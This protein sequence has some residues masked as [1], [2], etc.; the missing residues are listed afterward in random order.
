MMIEQLLIS[1]LHSA[2][3]E[4][5]G[6]DIQ[7]NLAQVQKTRPEFEGDYTI[8]VFPLLRTSRKGPE[9]TAEEIGNY[10][11]SNLNEVTAFNIIKGFLNLSISHHYWKEFFFNN[12][13][14]KRFG[15]Y[16]ETNNDPVVVEYS[17]PNN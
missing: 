12:I 2:V 15:S 6:Q 16:P 8:V 4:L 1:T 5:Y 7:S 11:V 14:N 17:S 10:L 3:S 9:Q 13:D